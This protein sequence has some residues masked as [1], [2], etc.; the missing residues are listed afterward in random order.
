MEY[1]EMYD[2]FDASQNF[3]DNYPEEPFQIDAFEHTVSSPNPS[4][5]SFESLVGNSIT[6][7]T[8]E[9]AKKGARAFG[10]KGTITCDAS[11]LSYLRIDKRRPL[12]P[13][14]ITFY[15]TK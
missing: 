5:V 7:Q 6:F 11:L 13:V 9:A 3:F 12:K 2:N 1:D 4:P 14:Q 15:P 8:P 10:Y